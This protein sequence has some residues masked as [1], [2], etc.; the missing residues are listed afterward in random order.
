MGGGLSKS[1]EACGN[2]VENGPVLNGSGGGERAKES[3]KAEGILVDEASACSSD[4]GTSCSKVA[5]DVG[6]DNAGS[7]TIWNSERARSVA[8]GGRV[9]DTE[10]GKGGRGTRAGGM[11]LVEAAKG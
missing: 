1:M 11:I 8:F 5:G 4:F 2:D 6:R 3:A 10:R 9:L 7:S